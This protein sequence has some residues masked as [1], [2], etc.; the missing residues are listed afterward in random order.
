M[1]ARTPTSWMICYDVA[2]PHRLRA[3]HRAVRRYAVPLQYSVFCAN[4][5]R[6][7]L[8]R[9]LDALSRIIDPRRD[10]V[11]AYPLLTASPPVIY[12]RDLLAEGVHFHLRAADLS[13][14]D[15]HMC[16]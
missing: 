6:R 11:R 7:E 10:D 1:P 5:T 16:G 8:A 13:Q 3:I 9:R 15:C 12:G 14:P 4:A 2:D